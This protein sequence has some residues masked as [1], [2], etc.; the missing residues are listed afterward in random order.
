MCVVS[1]YR[2]TCTIRHIF[3]ENNGIRL[4]FIDEQSDVFI[5][6]LVDDLLIPI[7]TTGPLIQYKDCL[8]EMFTIDRNTFILHDGNCI[9]VF[10]ISNSF[11]GGN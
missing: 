5:Y 9:F 7:P 2:H 4:C 8:W 11:N 6:N 10:V 1:D 3:A